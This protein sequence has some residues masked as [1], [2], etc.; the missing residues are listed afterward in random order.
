MKKKLLKLPKYRLLNV[1]TK[2]EVLWSRSA[3]GVQSQDLGH[4]V[5]WV[6]KQTKFDKR[7]EK[8]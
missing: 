5:F 3:V 8:C 1:C 7:V 4:L 2:V 6:T